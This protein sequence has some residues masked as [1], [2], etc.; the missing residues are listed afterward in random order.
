M[1][2]QEQH[3]SYDTAT[4][5]AVLVAAPV[6]ELGLALTKA[7]QLAGVVHVKA[8]N[9]RRAASDPA[10]PCLM[11]KIRSP[12]RYSYDVCRLDADSIRSSEHNDST[13][14]ARCVAAHLSLINL[15]NIII[16]YY[17]YILVY[18]CSGM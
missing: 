11:S 18:M 16:L 10:P 14:M 15:I 5:R 8:S 12:F 6:C 7:P 2:Q 4:T 17:M 1:E 13:C 9:G 3:Y